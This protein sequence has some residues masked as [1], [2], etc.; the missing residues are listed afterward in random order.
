MHNRNSQ[1]VG[2]QKN[3]ALYQKIQAMSCHRKMMSSVVLLVIDCLRCIL[4]RFASHTKDS[5][6][7][8]SFILS[9]ALLLIHVPDGYFMS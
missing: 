2:V 6:S 1:E 7:C 9:L 5:D 3:V 8:I 4:T